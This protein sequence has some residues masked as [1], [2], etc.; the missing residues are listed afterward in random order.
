MVT[1]TL[2]QK[3]GSSVERDLA[4]AT[5]AEMRSYCARHKLGTPQWR[6]YAKAPDLRAAILWQLGQGDEP[7]WAACMQERDGKGK[8]GD[9]LAEMIAQAV[10]QYIDPPVAELDREAVAAMLADYDSKVQKQLELLAAIKGREITV[11]QPDGVKHA[12]GVQHR[13]FQLLLRCM[14]QRLNVFLCGPA[15]SSKT[16]AFEHAASA[17][18]LPFYPQS[19]GPQTTQSELKGYMSAVGE[20][21]V[22]NFR[23]AFEHG[24]VFLLDEADRGNAG[25]LT[26]LNAALSNGYCA[27]PDGVVKK[28]EN[29]VAGAAANTWGRGADRQYVGATQLDA[30]TLDRFVFLEWDIDEAFEAAL[31]GV[32]RA[33][34]PVQV[35]QGGTMAAEEWYTQV[36]KWR[37]A[38]QELGLRVIISP[39]ATLM[40]CKLF[41][42]GVGRTHVEQL[43]VWRGLDD[44]TRQKIVEKAATY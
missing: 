12:V 10:S 38:A 9:G 5:V 37:R 31:V 19:V 30:A 35:D 13:N 20:Y 44:T 21:V 32:T 24:G 4:E 18:G 16:T 41:A 40:G 7:D 3:D 22:S 42:A 26:F 28:H 25:V 8:G 1:I 11:V 27:F 15:G 14:Q 34:E 36:T 39:R 6:S 2:V 17:L 29:F 33:S 43:V 23:R